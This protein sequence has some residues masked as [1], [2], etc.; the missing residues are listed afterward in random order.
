MNLVNLLPLAPEEK[1]TAMIRVSEFS[2]DQ[3]LC[4]VTRGGVIKRTRLD[5]YSN[6]RKSG[7]IA[8]D[9][10]EGDELAWVRMTDGYQRLIVA[11][12]GGMAICF[13]ENDARGG[14]PCRP[15][16]QRLSPSMRGDEVVG[17]SIRR[18]GGLLLTVT[19]TGYGRL[20]E[21]DRLPH[22]VE[23]RQGPD[24]LPHRRIWRCGWDQGGGSGG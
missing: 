1:V 16:R 6:A 7:L 23:R 20:S 12:R 18:E 5:A 10:D 24:Q 8:I 13:D 3:Y 2:G 21:L 19:E 11:T 9:L 15:W 17:M 22:P 14:G 4:M